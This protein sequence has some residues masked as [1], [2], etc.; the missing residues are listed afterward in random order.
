ME[1]AQAKYPLWVR[2]RDAIPQPKF[3]V[4]R[5]SAY[6]LL[7]T[8]LKITDADERIIQASRISSPRSMTSGFLSSRA[9]KITSPKQIIS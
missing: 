3:S 4:E 7:G 6:S 8:N 9:Q 1:I 2:T 5:M